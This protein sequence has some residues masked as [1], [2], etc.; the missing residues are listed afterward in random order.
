MTSVEALLQE[1]IEGLIDE[2]VKKVDGGYA[3]Y[4]KKKTK[5]GKRKRFNKKPKSKQDCYK[6]EY[7]IE[8]SKER[9]KKG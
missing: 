1:C 3:L 5:G 2:V 9:Q 6:Q 4:S 8:K 7:A